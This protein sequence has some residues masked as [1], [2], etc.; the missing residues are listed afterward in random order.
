MS[1]PP[2]PA[3]TAGVAGDPSPRAPR[4]NNGT[5]AV[6]QDPL[7]TPV[8]SLLGSGGEDYRRLLNLIDPVSI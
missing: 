5:P 2:D 1:S 3:N 6:R 8:T 7:Q 4:M